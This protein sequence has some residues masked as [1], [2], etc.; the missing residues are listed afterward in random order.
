M[1]QQLMFEFVW[2]SRNV[3]CSVFNFIL[4]HLCIN[5]M[6]APSQFHSIVNRNKPLRRTPFGD[7]CIKYSKWREKL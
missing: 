3:F 7:S 4:S 2:F 1:G 5:K 6:L